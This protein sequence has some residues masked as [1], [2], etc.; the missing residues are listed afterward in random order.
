[1]RPS[2][3]KL[4]HPLDMYA[5][6]V[7]A[8][9][10]QPL[11]LAQTL[12]SLGWKLAD[13]AWAAVHWTP[14]WLAAAIAAGKQ[15]RGIKLPSLSDEVVTP[16]EDKAFTGQTASFGQATTDHPQHPSPFQG[17][18]E[19]GDFHRNGRTQGARA[20][21]CG[22][23]HQRG[24]PTPRNDGGTRGF[25]GGSGRPRKVLCPRPAGSRSKAVSGPR[26]RSCPRRLSPGWSGSRSSA[27]GRKWPWSRS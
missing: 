16:L 9:G 4:N 23:S 1:M 20:S 3:P 13:A 7:Q 24:R 10:A 27:R 2:P 19:H 25:L 5:A 14:D 11:R 21:A 15:C 22:T 6:I 12:Q 26:A 18:I 8:H 17:S